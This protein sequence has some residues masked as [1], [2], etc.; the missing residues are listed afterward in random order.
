M[1]YDY[2]GQSFESQDTR[3][4]HPIFKITDE[5]TSYNFPEHLNQEEIFL[6]QQ[7]Y[8]IEVDLNCLT[9]TELE[10][11]NQVEKLAYD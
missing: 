6:P 5:R 11:I 2:S 3:F 9:P 4:Q 7:L 1:V 8:E 10:V